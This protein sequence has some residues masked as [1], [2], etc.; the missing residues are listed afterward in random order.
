MSIGIYLRLSLADGDL[1]GPKKESNSIE[2]QRLLLR[3]YIYSHDD[4]VGDIVEYVDDGYTG[5]NFNRPG[6]ERMI[7][8]AR[9][10]VI[11]VL[12]AK[13]LSRLGRNYIELGDY[14]DQ[15]FPRIG[16][17]VIA[18]NS[19]YDS[20][21]HLGDVSGMDAAIS[22]FINT[23]YSKDLSIRLKSAYKARWQRGVI[24]RGI[25]SYGYLRDR[26]NKEKW[27]ID[28]VAAKVVRDIFEW[29]ASGWRVMQIVDRLNEL[30]L[31]TPSAYKE[32]TLH[33]G[34]CR[35]VTDKERLWDYAK[36]RMIL[37]DRDY[38]GDC[39][40]H[41]SE[42]SVFDC[43]SSKKVPFE[44]WV[45]VKDHHPPIVS[46][47]LFN[48]A[49]RSISNNTWRDKH[50]PAYYALKSKL[51]C[52][53]CH[54]VFRYLDHKKKICCSHKLASG[55]YSGCSKKKYSYPVIEQKVFEAL[56]QYLRDV[57]A[58]E[59]IIDSNLG[60]HREE[61]E[62]SFRSLE[63]KIDVLKAERI[64]QYE[65]YAAGLITPEAYLRKKKEISEEIEQIQVAMKEIRDAIR[66]DD[67]VLT[68]V[69]E[70]CEA[71]QIITEE[72][73]LTKKMVDCFVKE[74]YAYGEERIEIVF[75]T[76][77]VIKKAIERNNLLV[78]KGEAK[79]LELDIKGQKWRTVWTINNTD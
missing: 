22:N 24:T 57:Q 13:D 34:S 39:Y 68:T 66:Q 76:E 52:G 48:K 47:E 12:L 62:E 56:K 17:R 55:E 6:F 9:K 25:V 49:Q 29:A 70:T 44:D 75:V 1:N 2:N 65:G 7:S 18:V 37:K 69:S 28:R 59:F 8:D 14:L 73:Q 11:K 42:S 45:L 31:E 3:E 32:R 27:L 53:N 51:R 38:T 40:A 79:P 61:S 4:L 21:D 16:L 67:E 74:V 54:L 33:I 46:H 43:A 10:G 77:D 50:E 72:E 23:M 20:N 19:N 36:V 35:K 41:K 64:R 5:T 71:A 58:L 30:K 63:T 78:Q 15:I 60:A 26:K